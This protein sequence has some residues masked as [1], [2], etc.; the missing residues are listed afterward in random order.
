MSKPTDSSRLRLLFL[1]LSVVNL[2]LCALGATAHYLKWAS[3]NPWQLVGWLLSMVFLLIAFLPG[4]S[5]LGTNFKSVIKPKTAFFVFWILF[6][7]VAHLWNFRTAPWNGD[8]LFD[9]SAVD[10]LYLKITVTSQPF[11]AAWFHP[12]G[13]IAR[14]TLFHYYLWPWLHLFGYNI[15][16]NEAALLALWC[17]TFLFTLLL[18]DLFFESYVVTSVIALVFTFLPFAFIYTFVGYHYEMTAPLCV[19]SLYFLHVG[20]KTDSSFCL[21]LGGIAA[22][23]CL[24]SSLLGKQYVLALLVFV[25]LCAGFDRKRLKQGLNGRRLLTVIYGFAAAAMPILAFIVFNRHDYAYHELPFLDRFWQA[26]RGHGSPND[27]TYYLRHLWSCFFTIPGPRLFFPDILPIPLPYYWL[28]LP[29]FVLALW[30]KRFEIVLLATIPVVGV[31]VSAGGTVEHRLLLAIPFWI[32]LIGFGLNSLTRLGLP[33]NFKIFLWG[34]SALLL[35]LGLVPA[36]NYIYTK[37]KDPSSISWFKQQEVAVARFLKGIVAGK[38]PASVPRLEHDEFNRIEGIPD[39]PYETFICPKEAYWILHLFLHDYDDEKIL[40]LCGGT[41][42][43]VM[44]GQDIWS[45][46]RKAI[47][48]YA[49]SGKDLKLIWETGGPGTERIIRMFQSLRDLGTEDSLSFSFEG[50]VRTFYVLN[51]PGENIVQFQQRVSAFPATPEFTSLPESP[52]NTFQGGKGLG[53]GQFDSP[54]GIAVDGSG[55][56]L[57]ADTNNGRIE[58]FSATGT[59]LGILGTKGTA[60]GQLR[61]PNGIAVDRMDN[62]YVADAFNHRVQTLAP[63]GT[64][65]AEWKGPEPGFYGPRRIAIGPDDSIYVVDQGHN[66]IAKFS[67]DGKVLAT[68]G[69]KGNGDSQFDDPTSVAV[70]AATNKVYVADPRNKRIQIFDSAGK[71]LTKWS[72]PEWGQPT[73]FEDLVI[74]APRGHLYASSVHMDAVLVFDLNGTRIGDLRPEPPD[75]LEG[76]SAMAL[77]NRKLYVLNMG[78]NRVSVIDL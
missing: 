49:P 26:V 45:H 28:L 73:G 44:S 22:G 41:P 2:V 68:W 25:V 9:D 16:V 29:G 7:I 65:I 3:G 50:R 54:T 71:F 43:F 60:H 1:S 20:F 14:E 64:L 19:A 39:P 78:G 46:N 24:A 72:V 6:F 37:A 42:M 13:F 27:I 30:Q 77:S 23:L 53:R 40:S 57:V 67:P 61:N 63:D 75:R 76:P 5:E 35:G 12:Y 34:V 69:S 74:E 17:G 47:A 51:I 21:S 32:I 4:P 15:L 56:V 62:I 55:N 38:T 66:R 48:N 10:L 70:D 31:F 11:Q 33:L 58:K 18:T 52:A 8:G 36:I 59:F